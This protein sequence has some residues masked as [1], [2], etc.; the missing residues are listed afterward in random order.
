LVNNKLNGGFSEQAKHAWRDAHWEEDLKKA[1][2]AEKRMV[3]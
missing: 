2:E 1:Y 3:E